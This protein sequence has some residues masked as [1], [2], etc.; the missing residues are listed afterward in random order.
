MENPVNENGT[1]LV[2]PIAKAY[3]HLLVAFLIVRNEW[4]AETI[5]T[6]QEINDAIRH[7]DGLQWPEGALTNETVLQIDMWRTN[8]SEIHQWISTEAREAY[9]EN[10]IEQLRNAVTACIAILNRLDLELTGTAAAVPG[11]LP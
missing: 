3:S 7:L 11:E 9:P 1:G 2:L 5:T 4:S 6:R 8:M 10:A